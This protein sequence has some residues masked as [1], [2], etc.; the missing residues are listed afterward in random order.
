MRLAD[1][2]LRLTN[3]VL[4][5]LSRAARP[6][7]Q[8]RHGLP[9]ARPGRERAGTAP[10]PVRRRRARPGA[11]VVGR[12]GRALGR[13]RSP[14]GLGS[15]S[16]SCAR[17]PGTPPWTGS[18]SASP[19]PTRTPGSSAPRCRSTTS[20]APTST[21]P[22]GWPSWSTGSP[23]CCT[24]STVGRRCDQWLDQLDVAARPARRHRAV[25][26]LA[27]RCR[28]GRCSLTSGRRQPPRPSG[29]RAARAA[30]RRA[31][32]A[33]RPPGRPAH[34]GRL[35]HRCADGLL[36]RA[37]ARG[38]APGGVPARPRRRRLPARRR[39]PTAT[40]CCCATRASASATGAA[41]TASSSSTPSPARASTSW[42]CTRVPT[43]APA[44]CARRRCP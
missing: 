44:Q 6:G 10:V 3:P 43:S 4:E 26:G 8:P 21:S 40:T 38:A 32:P 36:A 39:A 28:P 12:G 35:P 2:S 22:A 18:C 25:A 15:A 14:G 5:L 20:T 13:G 17:A 31:G 29:A 30:P 23:T 9:A 27:D 1:R 41:R 11:R 19:W 37:D 34:P 7:R 42:S 16:A 24:G 33:G